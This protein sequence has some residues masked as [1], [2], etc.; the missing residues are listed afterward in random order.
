MPFPTPRDLPNPGVEPPSL[1]SPALAD[2]FF[3][4]APPR[5]PYYIGYSEPN[6]PPTAVLK[7]SI[8]KGCI[9]RGK[10]M[11]GQE[12]SHSSERIFIVAGLTRESVGR[13]GQGS[14]G[15]Y[16]TADD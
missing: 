14:D 12:K 2:K 13:A 7:G 11:P 10:V 16:C 3:S 6:S 8:C 5:K 9:R 1:A 4:T 15:G